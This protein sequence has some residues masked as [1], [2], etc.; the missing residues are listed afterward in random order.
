M[1]DSIDYG[2]VQRASKRELA[3]EVGDEGQASLRLQRWEE[4]PGTGTE[5]WEERGGEKRLEGE[6]WEQG[7]GNRGLGTEGWEQG[8]GNRFTELYAADIVI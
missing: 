8:A 1:R 3:D 5:G 6:G 7:A 4:G 2:R